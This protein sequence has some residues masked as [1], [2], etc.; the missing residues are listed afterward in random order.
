MNVK[1]RP[2]KKNY[3]EHCR[4]DLSPDQQ[5]QKIV[6]DGMCIGCGICQS[7]AGPDKILMTVTDDGNE[8][9][10]VQSPLSQS[11]ADK[12]YLVCP[13]TK[14]EGLPEKLVEQDSHYDE[15]WGIWRQLVLTYASEP[16]IRHLGSTG[17]VLTAL[18]LYL[19]EHNVVDFVLHAKASS[20][21]P[22]FGERFI[23]RNRSDILKAAG[24]RYGPTATL[25]D[26]VEVLNACEQRGERFA[27]IGTPCDVSALRNYAKLDKRVDE[28]CRYQ[29]AMVC[30]GFMAPSGMGNFLRGLGVDPESVTGLRYRG[31]G[32]P[33]QTRIETNDGGVIEKNYLDFW[34]GGES[35]WQLPFRCKICPDGIGDATDIAVSDTWD[36]GSPT[37]EGQAGDLGT[38]ATIVRTLEGQKLL[39][40]AVEAGYLSLD[41]T[42]TPD[43]MNRFQ[44]HQ[45]NKKRQVW[46]RFAGMRSAGSIVPDVRGLRLKPLARQNSFAENLGQAQGARR[47]YLKVRNQ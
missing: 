31:Y 20:K 33:G 6:D 35:A 17:G 40:N 24:S 7:V 13:G 8:I 21:H 42:L 27:F 41:L 14:V 2:N 9:P 23:S 18:G 12:I 39:Q 4:Q 5:L 32:C 28:L 26:I 34:G 47:R 15:V 37:W 22:T 30:G 29:L 19:L 25:I 46:S 43:D 10:I 11:A 1:G 45:E 38:N 3:L 36:G 16:D 44:P